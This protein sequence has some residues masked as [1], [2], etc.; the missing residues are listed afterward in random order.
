MAA[1]AGSVAVGSAVGHTVGH[2]ISSMLGFGGRS[3]PVEEA[4]T[5]VQQPA[6]YNA[7]GDNSG[8]HGG[9]SCEAD[10]RAFMKCMETSNNDVSSCQ[11][12]LDMLKQCQA[13][14]RTSL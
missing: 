8:V 4:Q 13:A 6:A 14:S 10:S 5:P 11:F 2:G 1:T 9:I 3:A 7:Y 12:Y